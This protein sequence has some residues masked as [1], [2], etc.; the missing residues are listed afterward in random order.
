M[1]TQLTAESAKQSLAAHV[2][3]K[4]EEINA[5]YGPRI[6]MTELEAL[7][8]DRSCVRYP[9]VIDFDDSRLQPGEF[10]FAEP[11]G[12]LPENGFT[13]HVHPLYCSRPGVVPQLALYH[14][15]AVNY[16]QFASPD[17]AETF[18]SAA[19]GI[20]REAYYE[21]LCQLA[22]ELP[23]AAADPLGHPPGCSCGG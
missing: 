15:V 6:G 21:S 20:D 1:A 14:L 19:L 5:K 10:A 8:L 2:R 4:G 3:S 17:D 13:L 9:C 7:L 23:E 12:E 11:N 18:A 16:G 22:D